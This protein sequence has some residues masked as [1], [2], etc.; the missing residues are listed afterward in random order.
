MIEYHATAE[1][2]GTIAAA[3]AADEIIIL[4][5]MQEVEQFPQ[6]RAA[7]GSI[8]GSSHVSACTI[9]NCRIH[10]G[11]VLAEI[12][13]WRQMVLDGFHIGFPELEMED[14]VTHVDD[15]IEQLRVI[16][17]VMTTWGLLGQ[18]GP[19]QGSFYS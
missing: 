3:Q 17:N 12:P 15:S 18:N 4:E 1:E 16:R 8:V 19:A 7:S 5:R 10:L 11:G 6:Q 14:I 13:E 2:L 9:I